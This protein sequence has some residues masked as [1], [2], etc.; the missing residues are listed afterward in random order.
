MLCNR[1][2]ARFLAT[3]PRITELGLGGFGSVHD[4]ELEPEALPILE[5]FSTVMSCPNVIREVLRGRPVQ[6]LSIS[7]RSGD[8]NASFDNLLSSLTGIK[9]LAVMNFGKR[10]ACRTPLAH[11][12]PTTPT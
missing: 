6:R 10:V 4:F 11:C 7:F 2:L 9:R 12:G 5:H 8:V 3:Q 1:S